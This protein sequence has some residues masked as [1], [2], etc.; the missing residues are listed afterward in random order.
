MTSAQSSRT[1][2]R[3]AHLNARQP[4]GFDLAPDAAAR[5]AL[6]DRLDLIDLPRLRF[7]GV[8]RAAMNDAWELQGTLH[9]RVVQPCTVTLAPV[10]TEISEPVRILYSPH[11][12][13]PEGEE[14]EMPDEEQEPLGQFIDPGAVMAEALA[15]ALPLYPRAPDAA[16]DATGAEPETP[17]DSQRPFSGLADLL[18]GKAGDQTDR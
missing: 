5:R 6:A 10:T 15:L 16:L 4:N 12:A 13:A 9:A 1:R 7:T 11:V 14:V 2:L 18:A 8:I 17:D 3:V